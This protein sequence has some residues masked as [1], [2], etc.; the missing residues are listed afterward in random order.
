M[1]HPDSLEVGDQNVNSLGE[2]VFHTP[3]KRRVPHATKPTAKAVALAKPSSAIEKFFSC[4][5]PPSKLPTLK[6]K[7][8]SRVLTSSENRQLQEKEQKKEAAKQK[9]EAAKQKREA[10]KQKRIEQQKKGEERSD[11]HTVITCIVLE[12]HVSMCVK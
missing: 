3:V 12:I 5:P 7:Q 11:L 8:S 9:R 10:A 2:S 6:P 4:P 1:Y